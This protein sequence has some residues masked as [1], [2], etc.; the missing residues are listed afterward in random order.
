MMTESVDKEFIKSEAVFEGTFEG[1]MVQ[2]IHY[3]GEEFVTLR[4]LSNAL[5]YNEYWLAKRCFDRNNDELEDHVRPLPTHQFGG[6]TNQEIFLTEV[7]AILFIMKSGQP[8]AKKFRVWVA[9]L[10]SQYR[11]HKQQLETTDP[12]SD[13]P[14]SFIPGFGPLMVIFGLVVLLWVSHR[15]TK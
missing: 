12:V 10:V 13:T 9:T 11:K 6:I 7:G 8:L 14:A 2:F 15:R 5:Q 1:T 3:D 4:N